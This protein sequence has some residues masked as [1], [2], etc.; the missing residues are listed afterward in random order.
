M[1]DPN[2]N[3]IIMKSLQLRG[4]RQITEPRKY[5]LVCVIFFF[6]GM[7]FLYFV[8][9]RFGNF[10]LIPYKSKIISNMFRT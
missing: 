4:H 8:S 7:C 1:F 2:D 3:P 10:M 9:H 6:F 5:C